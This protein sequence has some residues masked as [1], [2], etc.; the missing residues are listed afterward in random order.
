MLMTRRIGTIAFTLALLA[1]ACST[2]A[3]DTDPSQVLVG[4]WDGQV[5][6][7]GGTYPRTLVVKSVRLEAGQYVV[8]AEWGGQGQDHGGLAPTP[9]AVKVTVQAF[10]NDVGLRFWTP[11]PWAVEL[12]LSRDRRHLS[13]DMRISVSRG[14]EWAI[15]PIRLAKT[16][17]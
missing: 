13:G 11:E 1:L 4:R 12:W 9:T 10:G 7:A 17:G 3:A 16:R 6:M 15:N 14:P 5:E 8:E 2:A